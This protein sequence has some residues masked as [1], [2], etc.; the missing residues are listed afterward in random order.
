MTYALESNQLCQQWLH[1]QHQAVRKAL[2][3]G[4]QPGEME[5][6]VSRCDRCYEGLM[7]IDL[8]VGR[9]QMIVTLAEAILANN[10]A[11]EGVVRSTNSDAFSGLLCLLELLTEL[12]SPMVSVIDCDCA[13]IDAI[14][15][16]TRLPLGV[17][18][19][20]TW[21]G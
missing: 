3:K 9:V 5:R 10:V 13:S 4:L 17:I 16:M 6:H 19:F 7:K 18:P 2:H 20:L 1:C 8:E 11:S 14:Q 12:G 15:D 21:R